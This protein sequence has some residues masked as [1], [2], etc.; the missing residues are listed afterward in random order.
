MTK[1]TKPIYKICE[2]AVL[3][4]ISLSVQFFEIK[5]GFSGGS[6]D[7]IMIPLFIICYRHGVKY[8]FLSCF[9]FGLLYCLIGGKFGYGLPSVMLDYILAYTA[10]G[11]A[12]F[13][14]GKSYL[15]EISVLSGCFARFIIHF[16]SGITLYA[17]T[18]STAIDSIGFETSN[19]V[20]FSLVYNGLYML[21]NTVIAVIV[22][23]L[24][25]VAL[26]KLPKY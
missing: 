17:I 23:S 15:I 26:N 5:I 18:T 2:C 10:V 19:A 6:I 3:I 16:I 7:F 25:R 1:S 14:K 4:A 12:G 20:I 13:F 24:L 11:V 22:M 9:V 8:S 21:P